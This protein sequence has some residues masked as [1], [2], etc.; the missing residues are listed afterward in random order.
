MFSEC[1]P[2]ARNNELLTSREHP[3]SNTPRMF[4]DPQC[5]LPGS[6]VR[7][8]SPLP[9]WPI[10]VCK[11]TLRNHPIDTPDPPVIQCNF[12][13]APNRLRNTCKPP[14]NGHFTPL[15]VEMLP[16]SLTDV[17]CHA[18]STCLCAVAWIGETMR[19]CA[20]LWSG[21]G[22]RSQVR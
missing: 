22:R 2:G 16:T 4:R 1:S 12:C 11:E 20:N 7:L 10:I 21:E 6:W 5:V 3:S 13:V 8:R 17:P 19:C 14:M 18:T 15:I 9:P